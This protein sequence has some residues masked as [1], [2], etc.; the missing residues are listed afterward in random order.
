MRDF[1]S[2]RF[3]ICKVSTLASIRK[4]LL[5]KTAETKPDII[6]FTGDL[7]DRNH[8]SYEA[9]LEAISGLVE[10]APVYYVNGNHELALPEQRMKA[11]YDELRQMGVNVLFDETTAVQR[12]QTADSSDWHFGIYPLCE[13]DVNRENGD[14]LRSI[15]NYRYG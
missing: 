10:I 11:F 9:S 1:V 12:K 5:D 14:C 8:T 6:V 7:L 2:H 13:Q 4:K 15:G 3:L